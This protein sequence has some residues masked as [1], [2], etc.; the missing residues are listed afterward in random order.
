MSTL[1]SNIRSSIE[2][3]YKQ[4]F[5]IEPPK[6]FKYILIAFA[7]SG[8]LIFRKIFWTL[9]N[10]LRSYPPGPIGLPFL[11]CVIPFAATP[12][13]FL[14]N[15]GNTYGAITYVPLMAS[16]NIFISDPKLLRKLYQNE[17][18]IAR[19]SWNIRPIPAFSDITPIK[20]SFKRRKYASI[21]VFNLTNNSFVLEK[22]KQCLNQYIEPI[23]NEKYVNN[24]NNLWYP[25]D[26][27]YFMGLNT[28]FSATFDYILPFNDPFIKKYGHWGDE[29]VHAAGN[30]IAADLLHNFTISY[31]KWLQKKIS[32]DIVAQGDSLL[33]NWMKNNG[34]MVDLDKNI[35]KR[36]TSLQSNNNNKNNNNK[37]YID[38]LITKIE[39]NEITVKKALSDV[40]LIMAG[41]IDTTGKSTEYGLLLLAKYPNIQQMVYKELMD[42]M[43]K[44]NL[45]EFDFSILKQLHIFRSFIYEVLRISCVLPSGVPHI[46]LNDHI[47]DIDG[48]KM[49]IP[50]YTICHQN[51]YFMHKYLDW[52]NGNDGK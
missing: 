7:G 40:G 41:G 31:P 50:K 25:A 44:N 26:F 22:T 36:E 51:A 11:G 33:I 19:P 14:I 48:K 13:K 38:Y 34:F 32:H 8:L 9:L 4:Q 39:E 52:N 18:I 5:G 21:T 47:I 2:N 1:I 12:F 29:L 45:K 49:V 42:V 23:I 3:A 46:T 43:K 28:V 24:E 15:I 27:M 17:K 30:A 37:V 16:N 35:L 6:Y 20:Q 10:R